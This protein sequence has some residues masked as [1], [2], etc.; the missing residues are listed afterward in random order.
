MLACMTKLIRCRASLSEVAAKFDAMPVSRLEWRSEIWPGEEVLVVMLEQ[1]HRRLDAM[2]WNLPAC[3]FKA[4]DGQGH[5]GTVYSRDLVSASGALLAPEQLSRC[6]IVIEAFAYPDGGA[7]ERMRA[8]G[9][10][11]EEPL[12]AW[13]GLC[14]PGMESGC[15]GLLVPSNSLIGEVSP[16]MPFLLPAR[17]WQ[18]WLEGASPAWDLGP[19]FTDSAWYLERTGETWSTGVLIDD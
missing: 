13:A 7:G 12:V 6:L 8:W 16:H 10:L 9:G 11:W 5:R 2:R 15:A 19:A 3:A 1:G 17:D 14:G 18:A 4:G